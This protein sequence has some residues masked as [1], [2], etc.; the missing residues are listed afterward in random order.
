MT[1]VEFLLARIAED[2]NWARMAGHGCG[3]LHDHNGGW[4]EVEFPG[5]HNARPSYELG[6]IRRNSPNRL[7]AECEAKRRII[8]LVKEAD[9]G[10]AA[11]GTLI[12]GD[13]ALEALASAYA[14]HPDYREEWRP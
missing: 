1:I 10:T 3:Y 9:D 8:E 13:W 6:F 5:E 7:L 12:L 2:E 4:V 14:D 11:P